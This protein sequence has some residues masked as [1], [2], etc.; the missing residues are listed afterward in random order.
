MEP[1]RL[2]RKVV[3]E[4]LMMGKGGDIFMDAPTG[5]GIEGLTDLAFEDDKKKWKAM[6][7]RLT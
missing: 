7:K 4:Q 6:V 5:L 2:V 3:V 1:G